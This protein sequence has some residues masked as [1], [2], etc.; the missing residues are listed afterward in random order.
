M[1]QLSFKFP[2]NSVKQFDAGVTAG[3]IAKSIAISLA[4]KAV[5]A[6]VDGQW[7]NL[8]QPLNKGGKIQIVTADSKDGLTVLQK[9]AAIFLKAALAKTFPGLR[10]GERGS[11][12]GGFYVDTDKKGTQVNSDDLKSL[13]DKMNK[14]VKDD[15]KLERKV[16][17]LKDALNQVD[18]DPYQAQI[19]RAFGK[20]HDDKVPFY[21]VDDQLVFG[22]DGVLPDAKSIKYFKLL[23]VAGAYW[24]GKSS[25][26]M[27]QRVYAIVF[28]KQKGLKAEED[29][30][31]DAKERDHRVIGNKLDL[32]FVDPKVG[33][34]LPYWM[35]NGATIRRVIERY[36][37]DKEIANGYL[38]VYTPVLMNLN[39][40]KRSG[41]WAHYRDD[42]FPPMKMDNG[43]WL[44]LRP[45]NC[46]SHIRIYNQ[47]IRSYRDLPMRIA[48]LGMMHRYEKSGALQGLQRVRE[49]TLNDGHTFV[50]P[51][52]I[53]D[54]F[55]RIL[56]LMMD[57]Y[58]DFNIDNY[59]FRLSY[60]DPN[61]TK[62]YFNDDALWHK[63]QSMLKG[64]MDDLHLPYV[65]KEGEAAFYG[66]KLDVQ[67]Y[68]ALGNEET[69]STIQLDFMLPKRFDLHYV[70]K[71]GKLH[72][73]VMI[74]RG[75]V[76][77]MERFVAYLTEQYKGAF[78][79]WLA[80][81]QIR[82]I[83]VSMDKDGDYAKKLDKK[84]RRMKLRSQLDD[85]N[86][87]M[88]Y[89]I[90]D[91]QTK[92]IPYTIVVG[93]KEKSNNQVSVREYGHKNSKEMSIPDFLKIIKHD[94]ATYSRNE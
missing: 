40:Y 18:G 71:D 82:I 94:I 53:Q 56:K 47:H 84:F 41:H 4:K 17:S 79:T 20:A 2:D 90:R 27:L 62:K 91:S 22:K 44:E 16:L 75:I 74:H 12:K 3:K 26:P 63:S 24:Q 61:N 66:P 59:H 67:T 36:I 10:F 89:L 15:T 54:E 72:R 11:S 50:A 9:T 70:G 77:T 6:K 43:E 14:F 29:K 78:P 64:A 21:Q 45:M 51:D 37:V 1:S 81:H 76:S 58:H 80:P 73:P 34:G 93:D 25:N 92:K 13:T 33:Q 55:K 69:L 38:H 42:M 88:N 83:P 8:N 65:E 30:I 57:V 39:V 19:V 7:V 35:P 5:A 48:E 87:K 86:E 49:M 23:N 52:Q 60:R 85:R 46:P 28:Y 32:F 68:T 31:Q